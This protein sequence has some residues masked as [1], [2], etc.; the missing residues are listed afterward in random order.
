MASYSRYK[1][2]K[3][4]SIWALIYQAIILINAFVVPKLI[5]SFY[6][7]EVNGLVSSITQFLSFVTICDLGVSAV[8]SA[9]YYKPLTSNDNYVI[10][11]I[12]AFTK[13]FFRLIGIILFVYIIVL[14]FV[15]PVLNDNTF[16]WAYT[17][18]LIV[19]IGIS[20]LAQYLFGASSQLLLNSDQRAYLPLLIN[21]ATLV[22]NTIA[23][24]VV[25]YLGGSIQLVKLSTSLIYILRPILMNLYVKKNYKIDHSV[26]FDINAV[27][28]K[29][30]GII[31]HLAYIVYENTDVI[32]LTIFS[33]L[34]NVSVYSI[35]YM[36][37][38]SVKR[39]ILSF[40]TG[41]QSLFGNM[42]ANSE[43]EN[44]KK[45]FNF[46]LWS[47]MVIVSVIFCA[48]CFLIVPFV[49]LYTNGVA[50]QAIYNVP[51]FA[52]I[53]TIALA[54][55]CVRDNMFAVIKAA[56]HFKKTQIPALI[57]ALSNLIISAI[58]V[59]N[60]GMVGV[61]IGTLL[62]TAFFT[63]Y[64]AVYLNK[65]IVYYPI[66]KTLKHVVVVAI[67][68]VVCVF[69]CSLINIS[70]DTVVS[71]IV[72]AIVVCGICFSIVLIFQFIFN[73]TEMLNMISKIKT[74]AKR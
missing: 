69:L 9:A 53:I 33:T 56:G 58:L 8:V 24:V 22:I 27:K 63:I 37:I 19:S 5:L 54:L 68:L 35:Y 6:G 74:K 47:T 21:S 60:F 43:T 26:K 7:S 13:G 4:N 32:I 41:F 18:V 23:T 61:A 16:D 71:W 55:S 52:I 15:Y 2:L 66:K 34:K 31:Q 25:V 51:T 57:E 3:L 45:T 46:Y 1:K 50:D 73:R 72:Y 12:F 40:Y 65:N 17:A 14:A 30:S 59:I 20:Q 36:V 42:L 44:I 67:S 28:Q 49:L 70:A 62:S 38:C 11:K 64:Q 10:S 29:G 48:V 39:I